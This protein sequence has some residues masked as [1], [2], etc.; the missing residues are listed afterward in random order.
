MVR[1]FLQWRQDDF[2]SNWSCDSIGSFI[3]PSV[4]YAYMYFQRLN[5]VTWAD[6]RLWSSWFAYFY[7]Y[8][9]EG[10]HS[11]YYNNRVLYKQF[12]IT[13]AEICSHIHRY[14]SEQYDY[15]RLDF[16][17]YIYVDESIQSR[18][19]S[20]KCTAH[21]YGHG[22]RCTK[23]LH[24]IHGHIGS[25]DNNLTAAWAEWGRGGRTRNKDNNPT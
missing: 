1:L 7:I 15:D 22:A 5:Y 3:F 8:I 10:I 20:H 14:S 25:T 19:A 24:N 18:T 23:A 21:Y 6:D 16:L 11:T 4:W 17:F 12:A 2:K 13:Y 9:D